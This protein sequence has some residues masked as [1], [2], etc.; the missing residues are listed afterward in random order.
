MMRFFLSL[1]ALAAG[2][3]SQPAIAQEIHPD[4]PA[5]AAVE[6]LRQAIGLWDVT[7]EFIRENGSVAG[8]AE[9]Q[10]RFGWIV[11]DRVVQGMSTIPEWNQASGI[12]FYVRPS[13]D[14]IEMVSV[15]ADGRLWTMTG[16]E[17]GEM[18]TTPNVTMA[19]GTTLMLRFSRFDVQ[20]GSFRSR[21]EMSNDGGQT[22]RLGNRQHFRRASGDGES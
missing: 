3:L 20:P 7:T 14:E 19:D 21:M 10:Y 18:R 16:P 22:W 12:L 8:A 9:G 13:T 11:P 5:E 4:P 17:T 1:A 15:G 6:Q 2:A